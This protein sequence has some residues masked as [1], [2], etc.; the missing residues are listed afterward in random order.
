MIRSTPKRAVFLDRDGTIIED[1]E[2]L[3]DPG[4]VALMPGAKVWLGRLQESGYALIVITNQ[5]GIGRGYYTEED[6]RRV[7][8]RMVEVLGVPLAGIYHCPHEPEANCECRKPA[9][10]L[11]FRAAAEHDL[12]LESSWMVGDT[13]GDVLAGLNAG[14]RAVLIGTG[15][16]PTG[17]PVAANLA[18]A[19]GIILRS[20][21]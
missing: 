13:E 11:I 1:R 9:P 18:E 8:E 19:A 21:R 15:P 4:G 17:V 14:C 20:V 3:S 5:S 2:Y 12:D 10:D 16:A 7:T 6:Y